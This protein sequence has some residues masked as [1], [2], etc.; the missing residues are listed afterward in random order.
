MQSRTGWLIAEEYGI[1]GDGRTVVTERINMAIAELS[2]SGGG[3]LYFPAGI[4]RTGTI[5][6][7]SN[8]V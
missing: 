3:E 5:V 6:L 2:A 1:T 7:H 8:V 4:Y